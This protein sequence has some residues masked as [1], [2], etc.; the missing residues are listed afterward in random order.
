MKIWPFAT[1][2]LAITLMF[3]CLVTTM[4][5]AEG[6]AELV[7][8]EVNGTP[9]TGADLEQMIIESHRAG[10]LVGMEQGLVPRLIEKAI[11]DQEKLN[12]V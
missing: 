3:T 9:I 12:P 8:A 5:L 11:R 6:A 4:A 1:C 7:L 10:G 2:L